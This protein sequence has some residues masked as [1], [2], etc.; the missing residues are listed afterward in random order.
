MGRVAAHGGEPLNV[1]DVAWP[2]HQT[3]IRQSVIGV[4][5]SRIVQVPFV[6]STRTVDI[7]PFKTPAV[8]HISR[9]FQSH[10]SCTQHS[11]LITTAGRQSQSIFSRAATD[12][13]TRRKELLKG[14]VQAI[15]DQT[16]VIAQCKLKR[17]RVVSSEQIEFRSL[18]KHEVG[19]LHHNLGMIAA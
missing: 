7:L 13:H 14:I 15:D 6:V 1:T 11:S 18:S 10:G 9:T 19:Q 16:Q 8:D 5:L 12:P 3:V 4:V 17:V 2:T